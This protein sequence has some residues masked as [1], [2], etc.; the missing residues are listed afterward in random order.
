S[1]LLTPTDSRILNPRTDYGE[2][3][4]NPEPREWGRIRT[5]TLTT[6]GEV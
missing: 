2:K 1:L 3:L 5:V 6:I 4:G